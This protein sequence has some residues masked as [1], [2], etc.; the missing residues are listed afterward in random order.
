MLTISP[1]KVF[2]VIVK[3]RE[4]AAKDAVTDP[5]PASSGADDHMISVLE[6]HEDDPAYEEVCGFINALSE[7]E[8]IDLVALAWLGRGEYTSDDWEEVRGEAAEAHNERTAEYLLGTPL[9]PDFLE[10]G[11]AKL[12]ITLEEYEIGRL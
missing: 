1:E 11:L 9:A 12:G 8:Q 10:E 3:G 7:D 5:D 2:F 6:D 4:F